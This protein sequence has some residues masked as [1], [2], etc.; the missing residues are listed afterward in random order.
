MRVPT[1]SRPQTCLAPSRR[2]CTVKRSGGSLPFICRRYA[3]REL[4]RGQ[5]EMAHV[6]G[7]GGDTSADACVGIRFENCRKDTPSNR[8]WAKYQLRKAST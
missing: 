3:Y 8:I 7:S 2:R 6:T 4:T 1:V 5:A